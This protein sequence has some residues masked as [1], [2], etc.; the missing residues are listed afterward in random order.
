MN[1]KAEVNKMNAAAY[2][3]PKGW[4]SREDIADQLECSPERVR[5]VLAPGIKAGTVEAKDFKIWEDGRFVRRTG[6]R[7]TIVNETKAAKEAKAASKGIETAG[8]VKVGMTAIS[9]KR[10]G[11]GK[12]VKLRGDRVV[13]D[14]GGRS[15]ERECGMKAIL[16]GDVMVS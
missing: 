3:W 5:E 10:G 11:R 13:I 16:R 14:W 15:G 12:V 4:T 6:Y 9:R 8:E 2:G 1:W 7:K